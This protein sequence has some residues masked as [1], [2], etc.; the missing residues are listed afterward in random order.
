MGRKMPRKL[1]L[2]RA[3]AGPTTEGLGTARNLSRHKKQRRAATDYARALSLAKRAGLGISGALNGAIVASYYLSYAGIS[4]FDAVGTA[5]ALMIFGWTGS[6][7]GVALASSPAAAQGA[8]PLRSSAHPSE[9]LSAAGTFVASATAFIAA[10]LLVSHA[11]LT[12]LWA[13]TI[14]FWW[15]FGVTLQIV[16]GAP[17]RSRAG[18]WIG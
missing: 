11:P 17:A 12:I 8:D 18:D 3:D 4:W 2:G 16:A 10:W 13:S 9:V 14:G 15:L 6:F 5:A 7:I 1:E